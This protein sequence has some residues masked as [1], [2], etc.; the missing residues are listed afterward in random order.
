MRRGRG[1]RFIRS[2]PRKN[3]HPLDTRHKGEVKMKIEAREIELVAG[4]SRLTLEQRE[5]E[6]VSGQLEKFLS[7]VENLKSIE[8]EGI[9]PTTYALPMKNVFRADEVKAS[10][11]QGEALSNAP[12]QDSGYFKVP[13]VL[14]ES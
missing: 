1:G 13:R 6:A 3:R 4:L 12:E 2:G 14:E 9:E 8:T 10:L 7:Y 11:S 5:R